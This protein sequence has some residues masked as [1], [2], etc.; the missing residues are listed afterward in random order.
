MLCPIKTG[1]FLPILPLAEKKLC[2]IND[3]YRDKMGKMTVLS[4][5]IQPRVKSLS[6]QCATRKREGEGDIKQGHNVT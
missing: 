4:R 3:V 5:K 2:N 1:F 6:Y